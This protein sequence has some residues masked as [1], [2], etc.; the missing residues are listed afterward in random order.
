LQPPPELTGR[1]REVFAALIA[2]ATAQHF[3]EIDNSKLDGDNA[4][5]GN[6]EVENR[7]D[8]HHADKS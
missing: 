7:I 3:R 5:T 2:S 1:S 6:N 8:K 4:K